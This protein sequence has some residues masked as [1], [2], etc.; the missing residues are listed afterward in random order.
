MNKTAT[1]I[2]AFVGIIELLIILLGIISIPFPQWM[3]NSQIEITM[4]EL[5]QMVDIS[6][7]DGE[8]SQEEFH[9]PQLIH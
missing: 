7:P 8:M 2:V 4:D 9:P 3:G 6:N 1:G 5:Q